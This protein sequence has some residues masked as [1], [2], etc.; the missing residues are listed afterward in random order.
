MKLAANK[1]YIITFVIF[2]FLVV[3][4]AANFC[5]A[6]EVEKTQA[7]AQLLQKDDSYFY[8][9][10]GR[11][12]PFKPFVS[13]QAVTPSG[14]DPNEIMEGDEELTGM[15][16]FEPGQL[17]LVGILMSPSNE[18]AL[19]E[20]QAKKGYVLQ[21]GTAIGKRGIV[22]QIDSHQVTITEIAKT[23]SG[24]EIKNIITMRLNKEGD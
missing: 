8:V 14:L 2:L 6:T 11:S 7:I 20:D 15:R 21:V 22:T 19:V 3:S 23:R 17:N 13:M 10:E 24:K 16:L 1:H 12:D 4:F 9:T 18:M 5:H